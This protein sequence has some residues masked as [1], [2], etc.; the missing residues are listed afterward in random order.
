MVLAIQSNPSDNSIQ[1][2]SETV[3]TRWLQYFSIKKALVTVASHIDALPSNATPEKHT[4]NAYSRGLRY[5]L[6]W[7]GPQL[8]NNE[9]QRASLIDL[10]KLIMAH[11]AYLPSKPVIQRYISHLKQRGLSSS[12]I[13]SKYL[14]PVRHYL[15]ALVDQHIS[16][17]GEERE[18]VFDCKQRI[19]SARRVKNPR[20]ETKTTIAALESYGERLSYGEL[21]TLFERMAEDT[22]LSGIRDYALIRV[23]FDS[24]LRV[25]EL[26]RMTLSSFSREDDTWLITVRGKRGNM[27]PVTL[28]DAVYDIMLT[29]INQYNAGLEQHD[30]RRINA[31]TPIW[32]PLLHHSNYVPLGMNT[33]NP[34]KGAST[35]AIRGIF[36]RNTIKHIGREIKPHDA[37]RTTAK[38]LKDMDAPLEVTQRKLRHSNLATTAIYIGKKQDHK[39][40]RTDQYINFDI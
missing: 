31:D 16:A 21:S 17:T 27:D 18:Y 39:S 35:A 24:C 11:G 40:T 7:S 38:M 32:Q 37:R 9:Y 28:S 8:P 22:S 26:Q 4:S 12:T 5:F 23:A 33:F 25:S 29:Y 13:A 30:P 34:D 14:A 36:K 10:A 19:Q 1:H 6:N 2:F 3:D 15:S 20:K